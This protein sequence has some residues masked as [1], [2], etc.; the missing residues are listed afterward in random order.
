MSD[1]ECP[2]CGKQQEINHDDGYG[3]DESET[4]QQECNDCGKTFIYNTSIL[5]LYESSKADC[6]NGYSHEWKATKTYPKEFT[7]ME[8]VHCGERR[9][10]TEDEMREVLKDKDE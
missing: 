4:Y 6:L 2:Y 10:C 8:C 3:Y 7:K 1:T 5:F 9:E